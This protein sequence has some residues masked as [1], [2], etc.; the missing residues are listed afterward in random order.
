MKYQDKIATGKVDRTIK[1]VKT[2]AKIGS[3][4][5]KHYAKK[6]RLIRQQKLD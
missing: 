5:I 1:F 3:N 2:G 4:Y 6:G